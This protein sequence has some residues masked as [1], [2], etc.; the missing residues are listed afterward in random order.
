MGR[1][2]AI[3]RN[4]LFT[5]LA[6]LVAQV[7]FRANSVGDATHMLG[8]MVGWANQNVD[9]TPWRAW[10]SGHR[11]QLAMIAGCFFVVW[12]TP[13]IYNLLGKYSPALTKVPETRWT[14]L[15]WRPA[16][17]WAFGVAA[18]FFVSVVFLQNTSKFLYFQF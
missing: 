4:V 11:T 10:V 1:S 9:D 17:S 12:F 5:Y 13:N 15:E 6:V 3:S 8:A 18:L 16:P 14:W 7:F 2:F